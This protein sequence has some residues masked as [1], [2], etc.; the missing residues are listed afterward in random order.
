MAEASRFPQLAFPFAIAG[1]AGGWLSAGL[2]A[3]PLVQRAS[4]GTHGVATC[5]AAVAAALTGAFITWLCTAERLPYELDDPE[6]QWGR[7]PWT[8]SHSLQIVA[9]LA[10]GATT[11]AIVAESC[12][13]YN[14]P[15]TGALGGLACGALFL[16]VCLAVVAAGRRAK[17]ARLGSIVAGSDRRAVWGILATCLAV[18]TLEALP[19]WPASTAGAVPAPLVAVGILVLAALAISAVLTLDVRALRRA[20]QA[21]APGLV[22]H[23][24]GQSTE[25]DSTVPALDLGLGEEVSAHVSRAAAAYRSRHRT[26]ALVKGDP[27]Q[28]LAELRRALRRGIVGLA[29]V[30]LAA[31]AHLATAHSD[32][33]RLAYDE[34]SCDMFEMPS[35]ARAADALRT[36]NPARAA[37]YYE[38]ACGASSPQSCIA[39][40]ELLEDENPTRAAELFAL[41]CKHKSRAGCLHLA[42]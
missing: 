14:G 36:R 9:V 5:V 32:S 8:D 6:L 39:L 28:A 4:L 12:R 37:R 20:R 16:P 18:T 30:A 29:L 40:G 7:R 38:R 35:C 19:D 26:L 22:A 41:A 23:D 27:E 13:A 10:A 3:N 15:V 34:R 31:T 24:P 17:R 1:A 21:V 42:R 11:G 2:V 33:A 25:A